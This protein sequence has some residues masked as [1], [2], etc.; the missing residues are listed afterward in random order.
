MQVGI[1]GDVGY[2][3]LGAE[4]R[5]IEYYGEE[6]DVL[7]PPSINGK[8]V[9]SIKRVVFDSKLNIPRVFFTSRITE[10]GSLN[11]EGCVNLK[12]MDVDSGHLIFV[13]GWGVV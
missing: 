5:I 10:L 1:L 4:I 6:G 13:S 7:I 9:T 8:P 3:D 11:F 2:A 12:S